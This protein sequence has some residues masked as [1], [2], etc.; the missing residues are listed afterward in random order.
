MWHDHMW[1]GPWMMGWGIIPM[2][3]FWLVVIGVLAYL[4]KA[5]LTSRAEH[6]DD[7]SLQILKDRLANGDIDQAEFDSLYE[8]LKRAH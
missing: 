8:K 7:S 1:N 5:V 3:L 4:I 2:A 6:S